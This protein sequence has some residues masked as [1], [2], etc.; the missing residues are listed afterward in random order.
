MFLKTFSTYNLLTISE[1]VCY[2]HFLNNFSKFNSLQSFEKINCL[3]ITLN[4]G[5]KD[6]NF[7]KRQM[8]QYFFLL[9]LLSNQKCILTKSSKNLIAFKLK[10]GS[11]TGCKV[12]LRNLNLNA[13][14]ETLNLGLPRSEIF[15]GFLFK[16]TSDKYNSFSTK[17][18]NLYIFY[19][20]EFEVGNRTHTLDIS[21]KFNTCCDLEK[22]F[23]F[24]Y[25]KLPL[26]YV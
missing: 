18:Q 21:F 19:N 8:I 25:S 7:E 1:D 16:T 22:S 11:V 10:K 12:T 4:F 9:E 2:S 15:K 23:F 6:F 14:I 26:N 24:T 17:I 3:K 13:F 5:F 20:L